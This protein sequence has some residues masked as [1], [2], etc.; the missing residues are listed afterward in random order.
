MRLHVREH[1]RAL[2][3]V[4]LVLLAL[5]LLET[6]STVVNATE[7]NPGLKAGDYAVWKLDKFYDASTLRLDVISVNGTTVFGNMTLQREDGTIYEAPV[8]ISL[9]YNGGPTD[10]YDTVVVFVK[11]INTTAISTLVQSSGVVN[12]SVPETFRV[13]DLN[14][15]P[16]P[17]SVKTTA[18]YDL[19][20]LASLPVNNE[21]SITMTLSQL[22]ATTCR[23]TVTDTSCLAQNGIASQSVAIPLTVGQSGAAMFQNSG[24]GT[25]SY[26]FSGLSLPPLFIAAGLHSGDQVAPAILQS[27]SGRGSAYILQSVRSLVGVSATISGGGIVTGSSSMVWDAST[28]LL[29]SYTLSGNVNRD[30]TLVATNVWS[31]ESFNWPVF[32]TLTVD[33]LAAATIGSYAYITWSVVFLYFLVFMAFGA[34]DRARRLN[35]SGIRKYGPYA[36]LVVFGLAVPVMLAYVAGV[37]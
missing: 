8:S 20:G 3:L 31:P 6:V 28:G 1:R 21:L 4:V 19:A 10:V 29:V 2:L 12:A 25:L 22:I 32:Y 35:L 23:G 34:I 5:F 30:M 36:L 7:Y 15:G 18:T 27:V 26:T 16:V 37:V 24:N 33:T 9:L 11:T 14:S 17:F 13:S